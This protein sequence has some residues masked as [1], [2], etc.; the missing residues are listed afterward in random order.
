MT[1]PNIATLPRFIPGQ[2][3]RIRRMRL[4]SELPGMQALL[5]SGEF[6]VG[7]RL[8]CTRDGQVVQSATVRDGGY[9]RTGG[10]TFDSPSAAAKHALGVDSAN[11]WEEWICVRDGET[12]AASG[13]GLVSTRA[14]GELDGPG[15]AGRPGPSASECRRR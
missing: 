13:H 4:I 3:P 15:H 11:G 2:P 10:Q 8:L 7:D 1:N 6:V 14:D 12:L 5:R 9:I